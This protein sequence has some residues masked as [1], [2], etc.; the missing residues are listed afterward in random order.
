MINLLKAMLKILYKIKKNLSK[1]ILRNLLPIY[2]YLWGQISAMF[3]GNPS[4]KIIVI[5]ITGTT[6]KT[7]STYI[8]SQML[9]NCGFKTGY[10]STAMFS[11]GKKDWLNDKK[12]T[13]MGR[14]FTQKM[15]SKMVKNG[16]KYAIVETTSEGVRQF[17]HKAIN[18]DVLIFTG[19]YPEHIESHGSF[20]KYKEAKQKL[21]KHLKNCSTKYINEEGVVILKSSKLQKLELNRVKKTIIANGDD[22]HAAD[23]LKFWAEEKIVYTKNEKEILFNILKDKYPKAEK[24]VSVLKYSDVLVSALGTDFKV[25][26]KEI[27]LK[28][29]G[30]FNALNSLNSIALGLSRGIKWDKIING[31]SKVDNIP[32][33]LEQINE[34]QNFLA[35]IDYAFEPKAVTKLYETIDLIRENPSIGKGGNIIHVLGSAGGG[36]DKSRRPKLGQIAGQNADFVIVTNEDP[37]DEDPLSIIKQVAEGAEKVGKKI[38]ENLFLVMDRREAISKAIFMAKPGDIVLFTGKGSEQAICLANGQKK[39]WDERNVVREEL[40]KIL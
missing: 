14:G 21:F 12:M 32:G 2:H 29:L 35:V 13:M 3:Y 28:L 37:Y 22:Q 9:R 23:F 26:N 30:E 1:T 20:N 4:K 15:L 33:R 6:G 16:C 10:T 36:R 19:L 17:R 38:G 40:K 27:S 7:T 25:D 31:L 24:E 5:G 39:K 34:G 8:M 18:Y 11:D